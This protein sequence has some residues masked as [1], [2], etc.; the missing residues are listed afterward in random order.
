MYDEVLERNSDG[1]LEVRVVQASGDNNPNADDVFTR[2]DDG[3]LALRVTGVGGGGGGTSEVRSVNGKKGAVVLTGADIEAT[4][5]KSSSA[6][7]EEV[8]ETI[9]EHLQYL[10]DFGMTLQGEVDTN[11]G[12]TA[13]LDADLQGKVNIAQGTE[14]AGKTLIVNTDGNL[15]LS[16]PTGGTTITLTTFGD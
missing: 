3:K 11:S 8:T 10:N 1:E 14:N 13:E 5:T 9:T 2:D 4:V 12:K 15:E 6:G 7:N 16:E